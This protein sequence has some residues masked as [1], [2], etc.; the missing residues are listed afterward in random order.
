MVFRGCLNEAPEEPRVITWNSLTLD[1]MGW[2]ISSGFLNVCNAIF[3]ALQ[4]IVITAAAISPIAI[5]L[6][7]VIFLLVRRHKKKKAK[8]LAQMQQNIPP[9]A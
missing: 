3:S 2:F 7:A 6:A 1:D 5:P 8:R 4:W 9:Q